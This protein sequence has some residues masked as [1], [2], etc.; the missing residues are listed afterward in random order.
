MTKNE[1]L[2]IVSVRVRMEDWGWLC[3]S[4]GLQPRYGV[5]KVWMA[6]SKASLEMNP[7]KHLG[8]YLMSVIKSCADRERE[9]RDLGER[10]DQKEKEKERYPGFPS[11]WLVGPREDLKRIE[12]R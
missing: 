4:L 12:E 2:F 9:A 11:C 6:R 5:T 7:E 1:S 8:T 10:R 3:V